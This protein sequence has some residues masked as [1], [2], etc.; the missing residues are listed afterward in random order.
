[1]ISGTLKLAEYLQFHVSGPS[2]ATALNPSITCSLF[3]WINSNIW[4][5]FVVEL[6]PVEQR[7]L[8]KWKMTTVTPNVVKHTIARSHFR[9]TKSKSWRWPGCCLWR[10]GFWFLDKSWPESS[11][12]CVE[13]H[14]WLGCWGHHMKSP[15]FK[16]LGEHQKVQNIWMNMCGISASPLPQVYISN[17]WTSHHSCPS[18]TTS[19]EPS[20]SAG[21]TDCGEICPRCKVALANKS[22][23]SFPGLLFFLR[24]LSCSVRPGRTAAPGRNGSSNLYATLHRA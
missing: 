24:T 21:R 6:L 14:D 13:S 1:M 23:A 19:Q 2:C 17:Y 10:S 18:W 4:C 5:V 16:T 7:R 22:L 11:V 15:G 3:G 12:V 9:I 20:R 8:L